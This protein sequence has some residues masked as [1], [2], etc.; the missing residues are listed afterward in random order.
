MAK[1]QITLML[2]T[3]KADAWLASLKT[4]VAS[5]AELCSEVEGLLDAGGD[6]WTIVPAELKSGTLTVG[7]ALSRPLQAALDKYGVSLDG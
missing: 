1:T 4:A 3:G 6:L 7:V 2:D 5:N